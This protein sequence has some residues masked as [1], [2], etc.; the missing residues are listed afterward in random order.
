MTEAEGRGC[1]VLMRSV[2]PTTGIEIMNSNRHGAKRLSDGPGVDDGFRNDSRFNN[3]TLSKTSH[4][5]L[6]K[7]GFKPIEA[8]VLAYAKTQMLLAFLHYYVTES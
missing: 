6:I 5:Q 3:T 7:K 4:I 1:A 8:L 2:I